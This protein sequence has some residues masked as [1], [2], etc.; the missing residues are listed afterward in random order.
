M[1]KK[2]IINLVVV[3]VIT[4]VT[5][6]VA[7]RLSLNKGRLGVSDKFRK[8]FTPKFWA[9]VKMTFSLAGLIVFVISLYQFVIDPVLPTRVDVLLIVM[10]LFA[11]YVLLLAVT[12]SFGALLRLYRQEREHREKEIQR[13]AV[14]REMEKLKPTV[15]D[16]RRAQEKTVSV[17][18]KG[19][20]PS[21]SPAD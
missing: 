16:L 12:L 8:W 9:Y 4:V 17:P 11:S 3:A 6:A 14:S 13:E 15:K 7:T 20:N 21:H 1:D 2:E 10:N 18:N 19:K 5:T